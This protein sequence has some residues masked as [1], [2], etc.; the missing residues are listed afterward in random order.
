MPACAQTCIGRV[1]IFGD[2][3]DPKSEVRKL[4]DTNPTVVLKPEKGTKPQ[5]YYI[6]ANRSGLE[7]A[8]V[9]KNLSAQQKEDLKDHQEHFENYVGR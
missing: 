8:K 2:I 5:V 4:I 9:F 6:L 1:R 7:P 3:N